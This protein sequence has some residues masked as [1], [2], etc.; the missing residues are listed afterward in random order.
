MVFKKKSGC[1][2]LSPKIKSGCTDLGT[3]KSRVAQ[4]WAQKKSRV[5]QI[6]AS[7]GRVGGLPKKRRVAHIHFCVPT[8]FGVPKMQYNHSLGKSP[9]H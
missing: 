8:F 6:W 5:A 3:K 7:F 2:D 1:T 9:S 4:I